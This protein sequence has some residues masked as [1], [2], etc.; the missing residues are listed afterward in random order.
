MYNADKYAALLE[1]LEISELKYSDVLNAS[2]SQRIDSNFFQKEFLE[3]DF[4]IDTENL[5]AICEI[6]SGTTPSDRDEDLKQGIVLLKTEKIRNSVLQFFKPED[7]FYIDETTNK[8]M[9]KTQLQKEDVLINIVGATTEV[10][11]RCSYVS[12]SFPKA[13]ITQAMALLRIKDSYKAKIN[14]HFLFT[15]L[16]SY[17]GKKQTRRIARPTGQ[18]N[19]NL[20]EVGSFKI[21]LF[22]NE[23]QLNIS[24]L[25]QRSELNLNG[26][27]VKYSK[28][29]QILLEAV[30]LA[31]F[32]LS[33]Q[34]TNIKTFAQSFGTTSRLDAEYYQLKYEQVITKIINQPH[35]KLTNVVNIS[36]SIEPGSDAYAEEGLPFIRVSDYSKY[37]LSQPDKYLSQSYCDSNK[38]LLDSLKPKAGTVLFSKDGSVGTAYLL[39]GDLE[40]VTSGAILHLTLKRED[41][42]PEYLTLVLNSKLVQMQAER[43]AGGSIILHWRVGEIENVVLPLIDIST[44]LNISELI[45]ESFTLRAESERLLTVAKRALE[46]AVEQDEAAGLAYIKQEA[47]VTNGAR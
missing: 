45:N 35:A 1:G 30:G 44:Q 9:F 22:S 34:N 17:Y 15:F 4:S 7:Y 16:I 23:F 42:L 29:E 20:S 11:G 5:S 19:M 46:V 14:A 3:E 39:R 41:I 21:P 47:E 37:G 40:G 33:T 2:Y 10:I 12:D 13:N 28:A 18:F 26:S 31:N 25:I 6:K 36:K 24:G 38:L 27:F 8:K 43:D 32:K